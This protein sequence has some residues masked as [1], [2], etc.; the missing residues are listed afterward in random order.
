MEQ[1]KFTR[2]TANPEIMVGK[3]VIK[4]TRIPVDLMIEQFANGLTKEEILEDYP[5]ITEEDLFEV[6]RYAAHLSKGETT[7]TINLENQKN[8]GHHTF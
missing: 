1:Q 3:P 6:L 5:S 7:H 8:S 2:I 4:G